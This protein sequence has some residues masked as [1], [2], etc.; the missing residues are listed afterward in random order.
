M[1]DEPIVLYRKEDGTVV[2]LDNRCPHRWAP[3]SDGKLVG[4][5]ISCPYHGLRFGS[6]GE[7]THIPSQTQVPSKAR[8][9]SYPV[10][11]SGPIIWLWMGPPELADP[12]L[13]PDVGWLSDPKWRW[14]SGTTV[15]NANF[16]LL[17]ENVLD[18]THIPHVHGNSIGASDWT[19]PPEVTVNEQG[20]VTYTQHFPA[21]PLAP[22][23]RMAIGVGPDKVMSRKNYGT[24]FTPAYHQGFVDFADPAPAPGGRHEY[25]FSVCHITTPISPTQFIYRWYMGWD[26]ALTPEFLDGMSKAVQ[27]GYAEDKKILESVQ[28]MIVRD[29]RGMHYPEVLLQAD[30]A[31]MRFRRGL[32]AALAKERDPS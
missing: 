24:S 10:I 7:C 3:L 8:V 12:K 17:K 23:Y 16:R 31:A 22:P 26:I 25:R 13:L 4:D 6:Q 27:V 11:E 9:K 29:P 15:V 32:D 20:H 1:L 18:L 28:D 2:A 30:Q 5:D 21:G 14:V 19:H